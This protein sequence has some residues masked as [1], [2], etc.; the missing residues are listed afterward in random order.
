MCQQHPKVQGDSKDRTLAVKLAREAITGT[1]GGS[2][3][4]RVLP[5]DGLNLQMKKLSNSSCSIGPTLWSLKPCLFQC[6]GASDFRKLFHNSNSCTQKCHQIFVLRLTSVLK[7]GG[8]SQVILVESD[9][10]HTPVFCSQK[11]ARQE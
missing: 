1:T 6:H 5:N 10:S 3:E 4:L 11:L 8:D 7:E 2:V 9:S